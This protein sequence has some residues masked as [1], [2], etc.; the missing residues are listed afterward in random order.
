VLGA[1]PGDPEETDWRDYV[2]FAV[3]IALFLFAIITGT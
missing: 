2:F 1:V 3:V